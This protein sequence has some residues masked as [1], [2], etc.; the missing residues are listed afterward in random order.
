MNN[1]CDFLPDYFSIQDAMIGD[2]ICLDQQANS[3]QI[4]VNEAHN[5]SAVEANEKHWAS[6]SNCKNYL[7]CETVLQSVPYSQDNRETTEENNKRS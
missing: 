3:A 7:I 2:T 4:G 5:S 1:L 6:E